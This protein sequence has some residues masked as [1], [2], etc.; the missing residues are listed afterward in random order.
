VRFFHKFDPCPSLVLG[1]NRFAHQTEHAM[2]LWDN[3]KPSCSDITSCK[4]SAGELKTGKD[5]SDL[6]MEGSN[7]YMIKDY[8]CDK[9]AIEPKSIYTSCYDDITSYMNLLTPWPCAEILV[10]RLWDEEW[11]NSQ[12]LKI[13]DNGMV[14]VYFED[15]IHAVVDFTKQYFTKFEEYTDCV[16]NWDAS[17]ETYIAQGIMDIP[18]A[19]PLHM[20]MIGFTWM[21]STYGSYPLCTVKDSDGEIVSI[22]T[23]TSDFSGMVFNLC[24]K[25]ELAACEAT[26]ASSA[27]DT[28]P[29]CMEDCETSCAAYSST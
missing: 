13:G 20:L 26:C 27:K 4:I 7:P 3:Y 23:D 9:F 16:E 28:D 19:G 14:T 24:T 10:N 29:Y 25:P 21:H 15:E 6:G 5:I 8:L 12:L 2:M 17:F 18:L 22:N 1:G 11:E